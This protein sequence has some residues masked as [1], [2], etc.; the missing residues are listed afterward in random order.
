M[1]YY[2]IHLSKH[3]TYIDNIIEVSPR[4]TFL[5]SM[6]EITEISLLK[7]NALS[8]RI[9]IR[10]GLVGDCRPYNQAS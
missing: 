5:K 8:V 9:K 7:F 4:L 6:K 2:M 1:T 10:R 3:V